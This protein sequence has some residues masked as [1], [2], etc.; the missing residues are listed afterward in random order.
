MGLLIHKFNLLVKVC[1]K[2]IQ[3]HLKNM[4][5][6]IQCFVTKERVIS[7]QIYGTILGRIL[8]IVRWFFAQ[9]S[10]V[11]NRRDTGRDTGKSPLSQ[12]EIDPS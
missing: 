9:N 2:I 12:Q 3:W 10:W 8:T 5:I 6:L 7:I 4:Y 1:W 11:R